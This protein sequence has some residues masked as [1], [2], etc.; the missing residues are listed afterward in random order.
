ML[1]EKRTVHKPSHTTMKGTKCH[2]LTHRSRPH[3]RLVLSPMP[4]D[5]EQQAARIAGGDLRKAWA[6]RFN[7]ILDGHIADL[8][9]EANVSQAELSIARRAATITVELE[10]LESKFASGEA[11]DRD[12]DLYQRASGNLRRLLESVGLQRRQRDVTPTLDQYIAA[13]YGQLHDAEFSE[14]ETDAEGD[15]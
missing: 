13:R 5:R 2:I 11:S 10:R 7:D 1:I 12:L 8:G 4:R 14:I 6:R 15:Q 9:G 3:H